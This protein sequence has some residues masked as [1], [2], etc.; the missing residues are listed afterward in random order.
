M[1]LSNSMAVRL[2][3]SDLVQPGVVSTGTSVSNPNASL[4]AGF[5]A[6]VSVNIGTGRDSLILLAGIVVSVIALAYWT[7]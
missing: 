7:R 1:P 4:P 6:G 5:S 3:R 2:G